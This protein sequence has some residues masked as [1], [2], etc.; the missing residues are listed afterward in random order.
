[1]NIRLHNIGFKNVDITPLVS[2]RILF[3][4]A[5]F[6]STLRFCLLGWINEH[7][8]DTRVQFKYFGFE[9]V[10]LLPETWIYVIHGMMLL[11]SLGIMLGA[12]YRWSA[13]AF[14]LAFTYCE[15][16]DITYYLNHYYFVSLVSLLMCLVPANLSFSVDVWLNPSIK[17]TRVPAWSIN[18]FKAQL[19]F[20][21]FFAGIAKINYDWLV[22]ALPLKIWLPAN[23]NLPLIGWLFK[24]D[25][26]AYVFSWAGML[27]D[28]SVGYFLLKK[29]TRVWAWM[30]VV[31]FHVVTGMM[32]Q[33]GVFP[34]V[35]IVSTLVFFGDHFHHQ[36]LRVI[37]KVLLLKPI[38]VSEQN[39][40]P[41]Y[42]K[43][44]V[45]GGLSVFFAIWFL[46]QIIFPFRYLLYPGNL[47]WTEE[48][49]RFSWR[50][51]LM[52]KAG[53]ATFYVTDATTGREGVVDNAMFLNPHQEKQM[54]FQPDLIL[55]YA[56]FLK[57]YYENR[58]AVVSKVR[59]EIYVTLNARPSRLLISDQQNLLELKDSWSHKKWIIPFE[60]N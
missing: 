15:L 53:T 32:F 48:G 10:Q 43:P 55:Q 60:T 44:L 3:G 26:T 29:E 46:F 36:L 22:Q 9:W 1:M 56:Q 49:Y 35:M 20:V 21:Y 16:I 52:E 2:F 6:I 12:F 39:H 5:T 45:K 14:F 33:I 11:A 28:V 7:F 57:M 13:L 24:Y 42:Q 30:V 38:A 8:V 47:F 50:V 31:F 27:F 37:Q 40:T 17:Q 54:S 18:V 59:A 34:M 51:M 41:Y 19:I 58:G 25:A 4:A 23:D